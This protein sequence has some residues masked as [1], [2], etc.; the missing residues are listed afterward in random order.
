MLTIAPIAAGA[1]Q[2]YTDSDNYYFLGSMDSRWLGEGAETLGLSGRVE[3]VAFAEML[4]GRLPNG[5]SLERMENGKNVHRPGYDL[6]LSAPKSVS[7]LGIIG[8]D[9][10]MIEAH[11]AAVSAV[12][13][14]IEGLISTRL[15]T[16]GQSQTVLTGNMVAAAMNHDTSREL[17]PQLHTHLLVMNAT[18]HE[19]EW[20]TLSSDTVNKSGFIEMVYANQIALGQIYRHELRQQIEAMGFETVETGKHGL[21][22][23]KDVPVQ[24]FSTRTQQIQEA[25]GPDASLKSRDVA[26]LDTR[27]VKQTPDKDEL[28]T[29]W[30]DRLDKAGFDMGAFQRQATE[31]QQAQAVNNPAHAAVSSPDMTQAVDQ[32][33]SLLSD[34]KT[35]FTYSEVLSKTLGGIRAQAGSFQQA[36]AAIEVAI[37][38][39]QLIPL[40][41]EKGTFTSAIHLLDELSVQQLAG[42]IQSENRTVAFSAPEQR[43]QGAMGKIADVM[44]NLA[45]ISGGG[46]ATVQ[47]ERVI[48]AVSMASGQGRMVTVLAT[49]K[50]GQEFL[51]QDNT[52]SGRIIDRRAV[53]EGA[54]L[55]PN[56]TLVVASAEKLSV[57]E[58]LH[59]LDHAQRN[60]VQILFMD[61][62]GRKGTGNALA[63][64]EDA[65]VARFKVEKDTPIDVGIISQGDKRQ[66]YATLTQKYVELSESSVLVTVQVSGPREQ[67]LLTQTLRDALLTQGQLKAESVSVQTLVPV[68]QDSKSRRQMDDYRA[69][70]V[71]ERWNAE[72]RKVERYTLDNVADQTRKLVLRDSE[73]NKHVM[74]VG[75]LNSEWR[76][77]QSRQIGVAV[78]ERLR[79]LGKQDK[80]ESHDIVTVT[81]LKND[82]ITVDHNGKLRTLPLSD[83]LKATYGYVTAPGSQVQEKGVVLAA[84]AGRDTNATQLNTLARSGNTVL[85]YT[86][87]SENEAQVRLSSSPLYRPALSQVNPDNQPLPSALDKARD[88][89]LSV[90]EKSVRQAISVTQGSEV[91]FSRLSVMANALPVHASMTPALVNTEIDR[92]IKSGE[93]LPVDTPKGKVSHLYVTAASYEM[94]KQILRV[95]LAGK[96]NVAPLMPAA[97]ST[98]LAGLTS[99]QQV[100]SRLMLESSDRFIGIQG[101]AGVGKTTQ[102]KA[103]LGALNTLPEAQRPD[104]IGL[105]P[106][107]RAVGEMASVGVKAQTV[108]SFLMD[109]ERRMQSGETVDFS[110]T[111]FLV[112]E[113]SMVGNR[114]MADTLSRI[115][116]TGGRAVL[117]GD[118]QQLLSVENGAPFSLMQ[119]RSALDVAIM[120]DIVRQSPELRP[121]VEA[122]IERQVGQALTVIKS[123]TPDQIPREVGATPPASSVE[124][125]R[126]TPKDKEEKG[127][128]VIQAIVSDYTGRTDAAR[129]Q[130]L[131]VTQTNADKLAVNQGIHDVLK[132]QKKLGEESVNVPVFD[133][134][135]THVDALKSVAGMARFNG[136][137]VLINKEYYTLSVGNDAK[138]NG[139]VTLIDAE[140]QPH[141]LSAFESSVRDVAIFKSRYIALSVGDKVSFSQNDKEQ[142][143]DANTRWTVSA[144]AANQDI[145]LTHD[146]QSRV[147]NPTTDMADRH[148][149][150]A[151]AG[152]AHKAQGA[153]ESFVIV[154]AGVTASRKYLAGHSD[155]YVALSRMKSHVQVFTDDLIKWS[156]AVSHAG[157]RK[158]AH[159]VLH[160]S[161]DRQTQTGNRLWEQA[162]P[163]ASNGLG[164]A[165]LRDS[166]LSEQ[167]EAR[168]IS[169]SQ[170]YPAPH[171]AWPAYDANGRQSGVWLD[172]VGLSDEGYLQGLAGKGRL[173]GS[174]GSSFV[175]LQKS[176]NG[177]TQL[178]KDVDTAMALARASPESGVVLQIG[179]TPPTYRVEAITQGSLPVTPPESSPATPQA[180]GPLSL[181][182]PEEQ[183]REQAEK[184][185]VERQRELPTE[186]EKSSPPSDTSDAEK[187]MA[188][189]IQQEKQ[190]GAQ[191]Q[192]QHT[193]Q[194][195]AIERQ[196]KQQQALQQLER[197]IVKEKTLGES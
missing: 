167:G 58:M 166:G 33:I 155:A 152:T 115:A 86:P 31:R 57:K 73:G 174:E 154:L 172:A 23:I 29:E 79:W 85:L 43:P 28:L 61:T 112:D 69:G 146:G 63:T 160:A 71:M 76:L 178:A 193:E 97:D 180:E 95:I 181:K 74:P 96:N 110:R 60:S 191:H 126:Q 195:I 122:I 101:Y 165:L 20:R 182:T 104:V 161:D 137:T 173:L 88:N 153:S 13:K 140:G 65:G 185:E 144:I 113:S 118:S 98:L 12:A 99:G 147:I 56:S 51:E 22:E 93:L 42:R 82:K 179:E 125:Y 24:P 132:E 59:L 70:M 197:E 52:L 45:I 168:F 105:A 83:G 116:A 38:S 186:A 111:L 135:K 159:D 34:N 2:Y 5:D 138:Q 53:A 30:F 44:P 68:W 108:A 170:K 49:D 47:R 4:A 103:V 16:E 134:E 190:V 1:A 114:D 50:S 11:N 92:Q 151:Y 14:E 21:W 177:E 175:V 176:Q 75:Q 124:E 25:V 35:Q 107:H 8:G 72:E 123:V 64:L 121:A 78:G 119:Q 6:T 62:Q 142:G 141:L 54:Q 157:S 120:K 143:R 184:A 100:A 41:H 89:L 139:V 55:P 164:R 131:I 9:S 136:G 15:M 196:H 37:E 87:L 67:Q 189:E 40:D 91:T 109:T 77:Y 192:Q 26:A 39:Q 127:D 188:R 187:Q 27:Q 7:V 158:T 94:E 19:G 130:T 163:L 145:T 117:S 156:A 102:F 194:E 183:A 81:A 171:V 150:Y 36:R 128:R 149:D 17:D 18:E 162:R 169:G 84:V 46:G 90:V 3:E 66:R 48:E 148:I 32:A 10:R 80:L 129:A 106:T 133:R